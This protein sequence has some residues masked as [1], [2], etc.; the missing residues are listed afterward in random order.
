MID[1]GLPSA[2][3]TRI[4]NFLAKNIVM[5]SNTISVSETQLQRIPN[6]YATALKV[7][8]E[9]INNQLKGKQVPGR[10]KLYSYTSNISFQNTR[11]TSN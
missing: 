11:M 3:G 6:E 5:G 10:P 4:E 9:E 1:E 7:F 2:G 8:S